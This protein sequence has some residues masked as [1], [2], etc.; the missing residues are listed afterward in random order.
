MCKQLTPIT[1]FTEATRLGIPMDS[2]ESDL[3]LQD[4][5][6]TR[7]LIKEHDT[8]HT[9]TRFQSAIPDDHLWWDI[10]FGFDP[11]WMNRI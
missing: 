4:S 7:Q 3:Y 9:A 5:P 6:Q 10:P 2:H 8:N 1:I 11:F